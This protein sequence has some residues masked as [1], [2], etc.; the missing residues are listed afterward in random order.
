MVS[1]IGAIYFLVTLVM[2]SGY[3]FSPVHAI[4]LS[5]FFTVHFYCFSSCFKFYM[6]MNMKPTPTMSVGV[7]RTFETVCLFVCLSVRL[8]VRSIT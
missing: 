6:N 7:G 3:L 1:I 8:F 4:N 2:L 5:V